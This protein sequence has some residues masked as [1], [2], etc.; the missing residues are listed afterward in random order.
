MLEVSQGSVHIRTSLDEN[1]SFVLLESPGFKIIQLSAE[2]EAEI[3][4]TEAETP[5]AE[6]MVALPL[7]YNYYR[8]WNIL[9]MILVNNTDNGFAT[10]DG[11]GQRIPHSLFCFCFCFFLNRENVY[12]QNRM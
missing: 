11:N 1:S 2:T 6:E 5:D 7:C 9:N 3:T 8:Y 4:G 12:S 10:V